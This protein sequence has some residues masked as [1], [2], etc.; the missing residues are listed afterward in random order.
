MLKN[1]KV[2]VCF[3]VATISVCLG[4]ITGWLFTTE[5]GIIVGVILGLSGTVVYFDTI[6]D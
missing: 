5:F 1:K 6:D 2:R 3:F 4:V